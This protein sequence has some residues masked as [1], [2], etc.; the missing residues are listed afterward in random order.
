M[1]TFMTNII[2]ELNR[3][4]QVERLL[5]NLTGEAKRSFIVEL[6]ALILDYNPD[7]ETVGLYL[8]NRYP[9]VLG[10]PPAKPA[11]PTPAPTEG[12]DPYDL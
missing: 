8:R 7:D 10:N 1:A 12:W 6:E 11:A 9:D 2:D 4:H 3:G 5:E